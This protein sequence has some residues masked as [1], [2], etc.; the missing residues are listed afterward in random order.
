MDELQLFDGVP[1]VELAYAAGL[2]DG[3]GWASIGKQGPHYR[4]KSAIQMNQEPGLRRCKRAFGG[5]VYPRKMRDGYPPAYEWVLTSQ[6]AYRFLKAILSFVSVKGEVIAIALE[7][8]EGYWLPGRN[9][10]GGRR[11]ALAEVCRLKLAQYRHPHRS[12]KPKTLRLS[13]DAE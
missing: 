10:P 1:Q 13:L 12:G 9:A 3:E 2:F 6:A 7:F 4:L 11:E 8:Q 5:K